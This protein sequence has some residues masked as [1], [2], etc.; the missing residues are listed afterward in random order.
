[1]SEE[2]VKE[3]PKPEAK[4]GDKPAAAAAGKS[5]GMMGP[6]AAVVLL[7]GLGVGVGM[8]L[9]STLAA[10]QAAGTD[11]EAIA[12]ADAHGGDAHGNGHGA[13]GNSLA[14]LHEINLNDLVAN[15][16]NKDGRRYVKVSCALWVAHEDV[17]KIVPPA[18]G[19]GHGAAAE[20]E[21]IKRILRMKLE[22]HLRS[23]DLDE[24]ITPHIDAQLQAGFREKIEKELHAIYTDVGADYRFVKR[25]V[26]YGLL[27]Q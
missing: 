22:E 21:T 10:A 2:A 25:V 13:T 12:K 5:G 6:L 8:Y 4:P 23:Y 11:P 7:V 17:E 24:L 9:G 16:K 26:A 1:M 14:G 15:I 3:A 18:T 20:N 27:V 19:D